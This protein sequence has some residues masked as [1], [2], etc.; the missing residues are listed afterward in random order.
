MLFTEKPFIERFE[1]AAES[2]FNGVEFT[3]SEQ[4]SPRY[5]KD[6]L[7]K[8]GLQ[9]VLGTI[10]NA[11]FPKG[12]AAIPDLKETFRACF[13]QGLDAA[14]IT[15]C[16][17]IHVT[18]GVV[19]DESFH[20]ASSVFYENM[21]WAAQLAEKHEITIVLEA[22]NQKDVPGYFL[23]SLD[24]AVAWIDRL[25][26]PHIR[27]MIDFYHAGIEGADL[28]DV[29]SAF[30][31]H[32][33]HIQIASVPERN[34]P[35]SGKPDYAKILKILRRIQYVGWLG[36]E[37]FPRDSTQNGLGWLEKFKKYQ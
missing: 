2:G 25:E 34:E 30:V 3:Y 22:I 4:Y 33:S 14:R 32:G 7:D 26:H 5:I 19:S 23:R 20:H 27:L 15:G 28:V 1:C 6:K 35:D 36:C 18:S 10:P 9:H 24:D 29:F 13:I 21:I 37:Y 16:S 8:F 11:G 17:L 31:K 12:L